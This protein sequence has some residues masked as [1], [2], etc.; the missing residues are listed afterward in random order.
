MHIKKNF[1][2]EEEKSALV[3]AEREALINSMDLL[4]EICLLLPDY[5]YGIFENEKTHIKIT[6]PN[7]QEFKLIMEHL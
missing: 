6:L 1:K 2:T 5:F 7:R 4:K 3:D